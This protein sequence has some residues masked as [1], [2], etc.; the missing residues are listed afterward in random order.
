MVFIGALSGIGLW[1]LDVPLALAHAVI[2]GLLNFIPHTDPTL[3][4]VFPIATAF[5]D[6]LWKAN[7]AKAYI[8]QDEFEPF[9]RYD[10][11]L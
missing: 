9:F 3:S 2:A 10:H 6:A 7:V 1:I 11:R 8:A 5:V 4:A